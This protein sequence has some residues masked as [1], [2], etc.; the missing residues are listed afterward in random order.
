MM[1][2]GVLCASTVLAIAGRDLREDIPLPQSGHE[3][4]TLLEGHEE[5]QLARVASDEPLNPDCTMCINAESG[6][7]CCRPRPSTALKCSATLPRSLMGV[8]SKQVL[9]TIWDT[10][11]THQCHIRNALDGN[12]GPNKGASFF[13]D[14]CR[15]TR[16]EERAGGMLYCEIPDQKTTHLDCFNAT[17]VENRFK[18]MA[19][20]PDYDVF[21]GWMV[22]EEPRACPR[23]L[24]RRER[25]AEAK[26]REDENEAIAARKGEKYVKSDPV[27]E[28]EPDDYDEK[29][30]DPIPAS[31]P[32]TKYD[33]VKC[34]E[35]GR[36][37][38]PGETEQTL[39]GCEAQCKDDENCNFFTWWGDKD[40]LADKSACHGYAS[41]GQNHRDKCSS[42]DT[43]VA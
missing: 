41:C 22:A 20:E 19:G 15:L 30:G 39:E 12:R 37:T 8:G 10:F 14:P 29:E 3:A 9:S 16:I 11:I 23:A 5:H 36:T 34:A 4:S 43:Y 35:S 42:C 13:C 21:G 25:L 33:K 17:P 26:T 38:L 24:K 1:W 28:A 31:T 2:A 40:S 6:R 32:R 27:I 7:D 18:C